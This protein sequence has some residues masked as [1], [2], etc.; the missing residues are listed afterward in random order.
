MKELFSKYNIDKSVAQA[1][2]KEK[3]TTPTMVQSKVI[4]EALNNKDLIVQSETGSGK[5]F[6]YLIPLFKKI[7]LGKREMQGIILAPTHELAIQVQRQIEILSTGSDIKMNSALILGNVNIQRQIEKLREKPQLIVGSPGR[8][9]EL[10]KK[11]KIN[12]QTIKTIVIDEVDRLMDINNYQMIKDIVKTTQKDRQL[13][14]F[15]ASVTKDTEIKAKELMNDPVFIKASESNSVPET[16]EHYYFQVELREKIETLRKVIR[17]VNPEKAIVFIGEREEADVCASKLG[18][19]KLVAE[20]IHGQNDKMERKRIMEN[21][22]KGKTQILVA[23]D[24]AARGLDIQGVTHI[25][26]L[27]IPR[28]SQNYLHRAGRTGRKGEKG[29]CISI[30][31]EKEKEYIKLYEK[32]LK[33]KVQPKGMFKGKIT[34]IKER[35]D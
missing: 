2:E 15:S 1:L 35:N 13:L 16:I 32:E 10:I 17:I 31:T 24:L 33:I 3:I 26:N 29:I 8:I 27:N 18:Y 23:S 19:H 20:A 21:F 28:V 6:A 5:T 12:P 9:L 34:D 30:V 7:D 4:P 22:K 25:F 14:V 11:K